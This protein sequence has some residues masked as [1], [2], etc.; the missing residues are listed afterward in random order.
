MMYLK[1]NIPSTHNSKAC[2]CDG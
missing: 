2:G 1:C